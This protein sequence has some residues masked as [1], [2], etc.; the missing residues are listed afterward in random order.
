MEYC[1]LN[2]FQHLQQFYSLFEVLSQWVYTITF[3]WTTTFTQRLCMPQSIELSLRKEHKISNSQKATK[4]LVELLIT[5]LVSFVFINIMLFSGK[6]FFFHF[7]WLANSVSSLATLKVSPLTPKNQ[8]SSSAQFQSKVVNK[9]ILT[10][11]VSNKVST[12][13]RFPLYTQ[14]IQGLG[15]KG[16]G[17]LCGRHFR[18]LSCLLRQRDKLSS[19]SSL[20]SPLLHP[21]YQ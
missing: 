16:W 6:H 9:K 12:S 1:K 21:Y 13:D 2:I 5:K 4:E 3:I 17:Q 11:K 15:E 20:I 14:F 19:N 8:N 10:R 18:K 7:L